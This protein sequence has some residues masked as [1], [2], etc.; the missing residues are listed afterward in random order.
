MKGVSVFTFLSFHFHQNS[1]CTKTKYK[2][3]NFNC[4]VIPTS[5]L[6]N[7][8]AAEVLFYVPM[9][10]ISVK[11]TYLA[12]VLLLYNTKEVGHALCAAKNNFI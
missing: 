10:A 11:S 12:C 8:S 7:F 2:M 3:L 5:K 9:I 1:I 4:L 6:V